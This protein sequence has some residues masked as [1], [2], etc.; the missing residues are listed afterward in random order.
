MQFSKVYKFISTVSLNKLSKLI[1]SAYL[2]RIFL[3]LLSESMWKTK[4]V[5]VCSTR[6]SKSN[7]HISPFSF[8]SRLLLTVTLN[9]LNEVINSAYLALT[10]LILISEGVC[11]NR[12]LMEWFVQ[13]EFQ[14]KNPK[15]RLAFYIFQNY[16]NSYEQCL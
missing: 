10:S 4:K 7:S 11:N 5:V 14:V 3:I 6:K 12:K 9:I 8:F 16:F 1:S 2:T 15:A 13:I